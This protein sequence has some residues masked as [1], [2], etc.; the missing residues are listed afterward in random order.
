[1]L[2]DREYDSTAFVARIDQFGAEVAIP[3]PKNRPRQQAIS[4]EF[5]KD[6]EEAIFPHDL[7]LDVKP[8]LKM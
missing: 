2:T 8:Q 6:R 3:S 7:F 4:R 1:M 5:Y